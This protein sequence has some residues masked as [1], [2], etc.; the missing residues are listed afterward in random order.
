MLPPVSP[1]D[2]LARLMRLFRLSGTDMAERSAKMGPVFALN[3]NF[4]SNLRAT[5]AIPSLHHLYAISEV[6]QL[7]LGS[8]F[9]I[10]G[11]DLDLLLRQEAALN[12]N[13]TRLIE[14][15]PF[16][17]NG[18]VSVPAVLA[19]EVALKR[20]AF[21]HQ[22]VSRWQEVPLLT[23][24]DAAWQDHRY[25]YGKLGIHDTNAAPDI[26]SG[27]FFQIRMLEPGEIHHLA[28]CAYHF[29]QHPWGYTVCRCV[30]EDGFL[31]LHSNN[32]S[33]LGPHRLRYGKQALILGRVT[34]F[35]AS[36]PTCRYQRDAPLIKKQPTPPGIAPWEHPSIQS[37]FA[38]ERQ[39]LGMT[40][41]EID[42]AGD[43]LAHA[44]GITITGKYARN[45]ELSER[46]PHTPTAL[47]LAII[48]SIRL[49]DLFRSCGIALTNP[50]KFDLAHLLA[51][52]RPED[53]PEW[54][55]SA[56]PPEP[57][58]LWSGLGEQWHEWPLLLSRLHPDPH[59]SRDEIL[60]L[61]QD[62][63]FSGLDPLIRPGSLLAID[64]SVARNAPAITSHDAHETDWARRLYVLRAHD[65]EPRYY[66]G[67]LEASRN[68]ILLRSHP[69]ASTAPV[70]P[71][72]RS[73][74][75]VLGAVTG[76]ASHF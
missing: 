46:F 35:A 36:L 60:R 22:L 21:L 23:I 74:V 66:C 71:F 34:G 13:R 24:R 75:T 27:A 17:R 1:A 30:Y 70:N 68:A 62:D 64:N 18:T 50:G 54:P 38:T 32:P 48:Y 56:P 63:Y 73:A 5:G 12:Q 47:G 43:K 4:I 44:L 67:Y 10:F 25:R 59:S 52:H 3:R 37:L 9:A 53:L 40:R 7:R 11:I 19:P 45:I 69:R 41:E 31:L 57:L 29:V 76:I 20:N 61:Y 72:P 14:T 49:V 28:P 58:Q 42:S 16:G 8:V 39:R 26:P 2:I 33:F 15:C 65:R 51:A 6:L 55:V